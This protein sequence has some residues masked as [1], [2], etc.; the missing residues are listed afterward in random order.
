MV[1]ESGDRNFTT[2]VLALSIL[3]TIILA[4]IFLQKPELDLIV[5]RWFYVDGGGPNS[6]FIL[7]QYPIASLLRRMVMIAYAL[8]YIVIILGLISVF[9][10]KPW[11]MLR[12]LKFDIRQ[13]WFLVITSLIGPLLISNLILK[14][15]WGRARPRQLVEFGG[16]LQFS[17]PL[18]LSDQCQT[19]C[20]FV[21]GEAS[22]MFMIFIALAFVI[23]TKRR[24]LVFLTLFL[25]SLSGL[26]R[27]GL[28]GHFLSDVVFAGLFMCI[29]ASLVYWTMFCSRLALE[30][31]NM[32]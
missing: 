26:M 22:S 29:C 24:L 6:G 3:A 9:T 17:P 20:S 16:E 12:Y 14:D 27:I 21:S 25:G 8:W 31:P 1:I 19:N 2:I 23:P 11:P 28:G 32:S 4:I 7:K 5:Q 30:E 13:W 10:R 18:Y 15:H